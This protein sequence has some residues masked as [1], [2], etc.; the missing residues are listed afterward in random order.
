MLIHQYRPLRSGVKRLK[1]LLP[2]AWCILPDVLW[3]Q[4]DLMNAQPT[5]AVPFVRSCSSRTTISLT[6][7]EFRRIGSSSLSSGFTKNPPE[8]PPHENPRRSLVP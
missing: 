5:A 3:R 1:K 7:G 4:T 6:P 2:D 8:E